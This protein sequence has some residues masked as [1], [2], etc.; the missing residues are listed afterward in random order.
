MLFCTLE[1]FLCLS[2]CLRTKNYRTMIEVFLIQLPFSVCLVW[3]LILLLKR[4]KSYS[5]RLLTVFML[6]SAIYFFCEAGHLSPMPHYKR[7]VF[8]DILSQFAALG[9]FPIIC[10]YLKSLS[11]DT[12]AHAGIYL[13]MLPAL[14]LSTATFV[15]T[16]LLGVDQTALL[17]KSLDYR[18]VYY[19]VGNELQRAYQILSYKVFVL[20]L[21][22]LG[23][24]SLIYIVYQILLNKFKFKHIIGFLRGRKPSLVSNVLCLF[25]IIL[26]TVVGL[27]LLVGRLYLIEHKVLTSILFVIKAFCLF[28]I[29]YISI[30][31]SLPGG[32]MNIERVMHPFDIMSGTHKDYLE[33]INSGP[34]AD[35]NLIG[36]N[37]LAVG[38]EDMIVTKQGFLNPLLSIEEVSNS[39]NTNRTYVSKLVNIEYGMPF[40]DY[41]NKL[42]LDFAKKL[43]AAEPDA[44]MDY[45]ALKSGFQSATQFIRKFKQIEG[46]TPATWRSTLKK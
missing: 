28:M 3:L 44:S 39:L 46:V 34:I 30:I 33:S 35:Q 13:I 23:L 36:Y 9:A 19:L 31:P 42:R 37:K 24:L 29:G 20:S 45:I 18:G 11:D 14:L 5:G 2:L 25:F 17:I 6:F 32:Y 12:P 22:T 38:F 41:I 1:P 43:I 10:I 26:L 8:V 27:S 7:L 4:G 40:R 21:L 15:V 16:G